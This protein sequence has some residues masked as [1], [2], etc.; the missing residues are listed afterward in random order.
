M[1]EYTGLYQ[2]LY[3]TRVPI[4]WWLRRR[5]YLAF[6]VRE[7]SSVFVAWAV[8]FLLL[9][10]H[11]VASGPRQYQSFLAWSAAPWVLTVNAVALALVVYHAVT[12][13]NVAPQAL[14]LRV[15]GRRVP[16]RVVAGLHYGL[17][18]L[19]SAVVAW[20]VI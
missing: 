4:L 13:F 11:A 5:S 6:V 18:A 16:A 8:V 3:R 15:R 12:W 17:W 20:I 14:V 9:L 2:R 7:L 1:T 10:A 19:V